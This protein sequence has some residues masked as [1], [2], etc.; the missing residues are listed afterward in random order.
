MPDPLETFESLRM[1]TPS[2]RPLPAAEVRRQGDRLRR[3]NTAGLVLGS[4]AVVAAVAV[5]GTWLGSS[6]P[7]VVPPV[8]P[9][10]SPTVSDDASPTP[11]QSDPPA[12]PEETR[13]PAAFPLNDGWPEPGDGGITEPSPDY[14]SWFGERETSCGDRLP[15]PPGSAGRLTSIWTD[16]A[17]SRSREL[18]TFETDA[19][20]Q[21][22]SADVKAL[23]AACAPTPDPDLPVTRITQVR[24]WDLNYGDETWEARMLLRADGQQVPH[25]QV[26]QMTRLG[27]ALFISYGSDENDDIQ[28]M[29]ETY[30]GESDGV[31]RAVCEE[32]AGACEPGS[33]EPEQPTST[34]TPYPMYVDAAPA[35]E[36]VGQG[37]VPDLAI[38]VDLP[39]MTGDG[40]E[41]FAPAADVRGV[42][43]MLVCGQPILD[44]DASFTGRLATSSS[45]PEFF[46]YRQVI[47]FP[48]AAAAQAQMEHVRGLVRGC[49]RHATESGT[50]EIV[51][52]EVDADTGYDSFMAG[53]GYYAFGEDY[54]ANTGGDIVQLTRVGRAILVVGD[55]GEYSGAES[56]QWAAPNFT[57]RSK[58]LAPLL[59]SFTDAGC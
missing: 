53:Y 26:V 23:Y 16:P 9:G 42:D 37:D 58:Q 24:D 46:T 44:Q 31:L 21:Q 5:G 10:P 11:T 41:I 1:F 54:A 51:W 43:R 38:D 36:Q 47:S 40:G 25:E 35:S 12:A 20:A 30:F 29:S 14:M 50:T 45:G 2:T 22:F 49:E 19:E 7:D 6:R 28:T 55:T 3:R 57:Q 52:T 17:E 15:M 8:S 56:I 27:H 34:L 18:L 13:I 4:A 59:C 48:D 39:D 32:I 33:V